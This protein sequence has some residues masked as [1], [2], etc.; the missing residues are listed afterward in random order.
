M[1]MRNTQVC[2]SYVIVFKYQVPHP[3]RFCVAKQNVMLMSTQESAVCHTL[4][5]PVP[6]K[7]IRV[8]G[9]LG[10]GGGGVY[11]TQKLENSHKYDTQLRHITCVASY[12][13]LYGY[14]LFCI[15]VIICR[16]S[17]TL[18]DLQL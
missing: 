3:P 17:N 18:L 1:L 8:G 5:V 12:F 13:K 10:G 16:K 6:N 9:S 4:K 14:T 11:W 7:E 15:V 2:P